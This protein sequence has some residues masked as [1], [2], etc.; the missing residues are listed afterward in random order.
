L[1][2]IERVG[3]LADAD[4]R[5]VPLGICLEESELE[6][7]WPRGG[8]AENLTGVRARRMRDLLGLRG[9]WRRARILWDREFP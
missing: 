4:V 2:Y 1:D 7:L 6:R 8:G 5:V 3:V 9:S